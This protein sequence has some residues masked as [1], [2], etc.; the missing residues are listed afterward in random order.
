MT[1]VKKTRTLLRPGLFKTCDGPALT[2]D[3]SFFA[4]GAYIPDVSYSGTAANRCRLGSDIRTDAP[5]MPA[6]HAGPKLIQKNP[7]DKCRHGGVWI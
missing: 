1:N 7:D 2:G 3:F 4:P 6:S 5:D